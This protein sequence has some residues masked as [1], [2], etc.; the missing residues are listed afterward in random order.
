M[1]HTMERS[2]IYKMIELLVKGE[3]RR[4]SFA[5]F[6]EFVFVFVGFH[7]PCTTLDL[8][9]GWMQHFLWEVNSGPDSVIKSKTRR[10]IVI[11][12]AAPH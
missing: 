8:W 2:T 7:E 6:A 10:R 11:L 5:I 1:H 3:E 12:K 4:H 9:L